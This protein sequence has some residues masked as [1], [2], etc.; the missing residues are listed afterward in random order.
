MERAVHLTFPIGGSSRTPIKPVGDHPH[1][2][3]AC[4]I[5]LTSVNER[6]PCSLECSSRGLALLSL[7]APIPVRCGVSVVALTQL[8]FYTLACLYI[9]GR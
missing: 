2:G 8:V 5:N 4:L 9:K 7:F 1:N 6:V 3:V